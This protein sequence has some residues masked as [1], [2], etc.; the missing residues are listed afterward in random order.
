MEINATKFVRSFAKY[1]EHSVKEPVV[2]KSHNRVIGVFVSSEDYQVIQAANEER[3]SFTLDQMPLYLFDALAQDH[4]K[5][6]AALTAL[7][8]SKPE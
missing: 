8:K 2:V 6:K 4:E 3:R 5:L 1:R 7:E